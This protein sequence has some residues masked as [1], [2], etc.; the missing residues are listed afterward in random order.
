MLINLNYIYKKIIFNNI[1]DSVKFNNNNFKL[2][3]N[4][5]NIE[6]FNIINSNFIY[7]LN[8]YLKVFSI[9]NFIKVFLIKNAIIKNFNNVNSIRSI[10][11][12]SN[13]EFLLLNNNNIIKNELSLFSVSYNNNYVNFLNF[14]I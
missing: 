14:N 3:K 10:Y 9:K 8:Y 4:N 7:L 13:N 6:I 11:N 1:K 2:N 12:Y 5:L